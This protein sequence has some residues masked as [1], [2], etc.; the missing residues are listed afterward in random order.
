MFVELSDKREY[1][2]LPASLHGHVVCIT[3]LDKVQKVLL[4]H[5]GSAYLHVILLSG[6]QV[7]TQTDRVV[8]RMPRFEF[9]RKGRQRNMASGHYRPTV[10]NGLQ[11]FI[12]DS[13]LFDDMLRRGGPH[14]GLMVVVQPGL[15]VPLPELALGHLV[16]L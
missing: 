9:Y 1:G 5:A 4:A 16:R 11:I 13:I 15:K 12:E 8:S 2:A 14:G 3:S 7:N 10:I 6:C